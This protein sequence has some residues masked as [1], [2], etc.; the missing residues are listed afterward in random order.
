MPFP[1]EEP[2][3]PLNPACSPL[4]WRGFYV[5]VCGGA[6]GSDSERAARPADGLARAGC[7]ALQ[8]RAAQPRPAPP[9]CCFHAFISRD[10]PDSPT[11]TDEPTACHRPPGVPAR[12]EEAGNGSPEAL[13]LLGSLLKAQP[14]LRP[15]PSSSAADDGPGGVS[16][17]AEE[18]LRRAAQLGEPR[19]QFEVA[20]AMWDAGDVDGA[21]IALHAAAAQGHVRS[22]IAGFRLVG[23][24]SSCGSVVPGVSVGDT[25]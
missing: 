1:G 6:G 20:Q 19:A 23:P 14:E 8:A 12:R 17:S 3:P 11:V 10:V 21:L 18:S 5:S 4:P 13:F 22:L 25:V 15:A 7:G 9:F 16:A 2:E 24:R